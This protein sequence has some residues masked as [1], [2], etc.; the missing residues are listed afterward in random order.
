MSNSMCDGDGKANLCLSISEILK[1]FKIR[2]FRVFSFKFVWNKTCFTINLNQVELAECKERAALG[3]GRYKHNQQLQELRAAQDQ[4]QEERRHW[5]ALKEE[6][7]RDY[8]AKEESMVKL[9][10]NI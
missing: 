2:Y 8:K 1:D 7:E 10:V 3:W 4:L 6:Q 9:Q 5:Q